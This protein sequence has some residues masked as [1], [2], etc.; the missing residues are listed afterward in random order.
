MTISS[1]TIREYAQNQ[2]DLFA[3]V[4]VKRGDDVALGR[5]EAYA[6]IIGLINQLEKVSPLGVELLRELYAIENS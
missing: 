6:D 3:D 1:A 2:R 4:W 5:M